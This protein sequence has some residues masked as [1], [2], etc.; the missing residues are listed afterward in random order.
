MVWPDFIGRAVLAG[1]GLAWVAGPLG[2]FVVW[3]RMAYFGDTLAHAS[4]LGI[5]LSLAFEVHL[6]VGVVGVALTIAILLVYWQRQATLASDTLLGI[7][8]HTGLALGLITL[9]LI[10][11]PSTDV[12]GYLYGDVLAVSNEDILWI[13]G[14]GSVALLLLLLI[15]RPLLSL[16][17]HADLAAVEGVPVHRIRLLYVAILAFLV[18]I[19]VKIVGVLL[20]T[21]MLIIPAAAARRIAQAPGQLAVMASLLGMLA[22]WGG[23][24]FS[25]YWDVPTGPAMVCGMALLFVLTTLLGK[26]VKY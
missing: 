25:Y 1:T 24:I 12:L 3:Q 2:A 8:S 19:A 15:W 6:S 17:V 18:A 10:R 14:G 23:L 16:T 4:L 9:S 5:T 26:K 7:L 21:S 22:V 13:Y 20:V 11:K